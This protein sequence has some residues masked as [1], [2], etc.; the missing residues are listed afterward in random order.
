[1]HIDTTVAGTCIVA[2]AIVAHA[3]HGRMLG[4]PRVL[5]VIGWVVNVLALLAL[6]A[7]WIRH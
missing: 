7:C 6:A 1:M 4:S 5:S 2:L 3:W